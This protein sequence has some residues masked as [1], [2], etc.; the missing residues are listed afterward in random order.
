MAKLMATLGIPGC[1]KSTW[2]KSQW[3]PPVVVVE[4]DQIRVDL[5]GSRAD[6]SR[7]DEVFQT[8]YDRVEGALKEGRDVIFDSTGLSR[9]GVARRAIITDMASATGAVAELHVFRTPFQTAV[10]RNALRDLSMVVPFDVMLMFLSLY[11]EALFSIGSE[12]W[13]RIVFHD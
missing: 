7:N 1:G 12:A 10:E 13:D 4:T 9:N 3:F 8:A 2:V 5:T 11:K 6:Q